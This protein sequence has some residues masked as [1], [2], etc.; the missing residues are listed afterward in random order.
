MHCE[1]LKLRNKGDHLQDSMADA[2]GMEWAEHLVQARVPNITPQGGTW[3]EVDGPALLAAAS[4]LQL[5][6]A[7]VHFLTRLQRLAAAAARLP[8]RPQA[9][10]LSSS[11]VKKLL[12][13]P[14]VSGADVR[15]QEDAYEGIYVTE[16]PYTGGARRVLEGIS[17][18]GGARTASSLLAGVIG[19][20]EDTFPA[21]YV[22]RVKALAACLLDLSDSV[23]SNAGLER[24]FVNLHRD[25]SVSV[26]SAERLAD[27]SAYVQFHST[28]LWA[29]L[30]D[31][32]REYLEDKLVQNGAEIPD[33]RQGDFID[34]GIILKPLI[35]SGSVLT[36]ASPGHLLA[37]LRHHIIRES[38]EWGCSAALADALRD[39]TAHEA[40]KLLQSIP[41]E[42]LEFT[43]SGDGYLRSITAFDQ[44]K[45]LDVICLV[46]DLT[47]YN[48][49]AI[50]Q[51]WRA[52]ELSER[53]HEIFSASD[54][55]PEKT[56]RIVAH[57]GVGRD[58]A[59][60]IPNTES[61]TP[62]LFLSIDD[63]ET[64]LQ[65]PG[66]DTTTLW[67]FA[68][69]RERLE[70]DVRV[71]AFSAVDVFS[72][73]RDH[74]DSFYMG[75][76]SRP[77]MI[78]FEVGY[79]QQLRVDNYR[80][81]DRHWVVDPTARVLSEAY[82]I[83]GR[84]SAPIY[85]VLGRSEAS[86]IVEAGDSTL[87][88]R[89][90]KDPG[91]TATSSYDLGQAVAYWFWQL[92]TVHPLLLTPNDDNS[93][94]E[95]DLTTRPSG[96]GSPA[97][98]ED[99]RRWISAQMT[100]SGRI[101]LSFSAPP[102]PAVDDPPNYLDRDLVSTLLDT[103]ASDEPASPVMNVLLDRVAPPG[104][105]QMI[106]VYDGGN[107]VAEYPGNLPEARRLQP[108]PVAKVLDALGDF[109]TEQQGLLPGPVGK[110]QRTSFLNDQVTRWLMDQLHETV[111]A[112]SR[113]G[114]LEK[115]ITLDEALSS[116]TARE[117]AQLRA[118]L[119]CFGASDNQVL[120]LQD[121]QTKAVASSLA[122]RFLIEYVTAVGPTGSLPLTNET[123]DHML[124]L[125]SEIINKGMLS[126]AIRHNI[127]DAEVS[128]LGSGR[129]G[130]SRDEDKYH[131][132]LTQFGDT[133]A[134]LTF[135]AALATHLKDVDDEDLY[136]LPDADALAELEFGFSFTDLAEACGQIISL[137]DNDG[138][139]DVFTVNR[140]DIREKLTTDVGWDKVKIEALLNALTLSSRASTAAEYWKSGPSVFPWRFNR[141]LSYLRRPLL[142]TGPHDA[143]RITA[144]RRRLWQTASFWLE[145][146]NTG[147]LQAK[148][149]PMKAALNKIRSAK[150]DSFELAVAN[151]LKAAGLTGVRCRLSR[152]GRHD[153]RNIDGVNLGDIDAIGVDERNRR[154]Y[155]VEAKDFE[156]A[157][158][159]AELANE[160][161]NLLTSDK[162]AV[163]RLALRADWVR[164]HVAPTL[165]ELRI[166][167]H[168]GS[169]TVLP[170]V[171]VDER[172]LSARMSTSETPIISISELEDYVRAA[173]AKS[174]RRRR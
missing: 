170:L 107:L 89:L 50:F 5:I 28:R 100:E 84:D 80:R 65:S 164:R 98:R 103:L 86:T 149:K 2:D 14:F 69:A 171:V 127:S 70:R 160:I 58:M 102:P 157:R 173:N 60:G 49:S 116:E 64:I 165:N 155:V 7:N 6:A 75:D 114:V 146:F 122:S 38:Y 159:P 139:K 140:A 172:L 40:R 151:G 131:R 71:L 73:Y 113:Q 53:I 135:E 124:A 169:W 16:V 1:M 77:T 99:E 168:R 15:R 41:D 104:H 25:Q 101:T 62:T 35:R 91:G 92:M 147:R 48:P 130:I 63:L 174:T 128:I 4:S 88:V 125:G 163:K 78:S 123:Y 143:T 76:E 83:H 51:P 11:T 119:A 134:Q 90:G 145:Q 105:K 34:D 18:G 136:S 121:Q 126:D 45:T 96:T 42:P 12:A 23:T 22:V 27:L 153:F 20:A 85:L 167:A 150:G 61:S 108:A 161:D 59:F 137:G 66:T 24:G 148:T 79:G 144:G 26:P 162:A 9:R 57:Q 141:D 46:D 120:K 47:D 55:L 21:G 110:D 39:V 156:V 56:L 8:A 13:D 115:L 117:P 112:L 52:P 111:S 95:V 19:S 152:I 166:D 158:T 118:R 142:Q 106:H 93:I 31:Y 94:L 44:D 17:E 138:F 29:G 109:L 43:E 37:C 81:I 68:L 33:W 72:F 67:Y 132:A 30:P 74:H 10:R 3:D 87:W 36:L 133:R 129:L 82:A 54:T 97:G 32:V 154:I